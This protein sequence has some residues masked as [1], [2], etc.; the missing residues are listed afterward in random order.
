MPSMP[1]SDAQED[2]SKRSPD[3]VRQDECW[4]SQIT[5]DQAV[6]IYARFCRARYGTG[7]SQIVA[8]KAVELRSQ[9]D[10]E[11]ERVW[12]KVKREIE[13]QGAT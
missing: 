8:Q 10:A 1:T 9:G 12:K 11:G 13:T 6:D 5:T 3:N 7:A 2:Q 4:F